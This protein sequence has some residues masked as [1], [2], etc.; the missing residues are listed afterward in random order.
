MIQAAAVAGVLSLVGVVVNSR[1]AAPSQSQADS[2][3]GQQ[4]GRDINF[5]FNV[6][7]AISHPTGLPQSSEDLQGHLEE[8]IR[9]L[10]TSAKYF[11]EG[12]RSEAKRMAAALRV[13]FHDSETAASL[14]AQLR[15]R[16]S[17]NFPNTVYG[18]CA[19][20]AIPYSGLTFEQGGPESGTYEARLGFP[21]S[22]KLPTDL[23]AELRSPCS[24]PPQYLSFEPWWS[25]I[26][27]D[28]KKGVRFTRKGL[29][30]AV[31]ETDGG[32]GVSSNLDPNYIRLS[33]ENAIGWTVRG[34]PLQG[35][36]LAAIRE[37]TWETLEALDRHTLTDTAR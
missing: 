2:P 34:R 30:L 29:V 15:I 32:V 17:L 25:T 23:P 27:I 11:D 10:Q 19:E 16:D 26:V 1:C 7:P 18:D 35:A 22:R 31:A 5:N 36:E 3:G 37:V 20:N 4:A 33:R 21:L 14:T 13:L 28:D 8:Q 9:F 12:K 6:P 24:T